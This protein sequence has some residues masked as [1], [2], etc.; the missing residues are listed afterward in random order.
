[1]APPAPT[2]PPV[3]AAAPAAVDRTRRSHRDRPRQ[4][5]RAR[6]AGSVIGG[7][8]QRGTAVATHCRAGGETREPEEATRGDRARRVMT[9]HRRRWLGFAAAATAGAASARF[10]VAQAWPARPFRLVVPLPAGG[11]ADII[12]RL[13]AA[14]LERLGQPVIVDNKPARAPQSASSRSSPRRPTATRCW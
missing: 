2:P 8:R 11:A 10:A 14:R 1:M 9:I 7:R 5:A 4:P 12:A 6:R 13:F 3:P